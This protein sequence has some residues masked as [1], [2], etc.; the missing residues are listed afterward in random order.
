MKRLGLVFLIFISCQ[1]QEIATEFTGNE[2]VYAL[3]AGSSYSVN[4]TVT[5]KERK[6]GSSTILVALSGT[7]GAPEHPVHLHLGPIGTPDAEIAALLNS[8]KD[9]SGKSETNLQRLADESTISYQQLITLNACIKVH[10]AAS[11]PDRDIILAG[12]NIGAA[13]SAAASARSVMAVCQ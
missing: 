5:I 9:S 4:G 10:L 2:V 7:D 8:V 1:D 13:L 3:Q 6:D 11:G 12:G